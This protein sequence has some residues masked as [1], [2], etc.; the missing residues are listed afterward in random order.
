M[1]KIICIGDSL[2][3]GYGVDP[4]E[5]WVER[6]N[7][8]LNIQFINKGINGDT[9][10]GMLSRFHCDVVEEKPQ[11]VLI[12]GGVNDLI[13][14]SSTEM[15]GTNMMAMIHQA[16][17]YGIIPIAG[18]PIKADP[19]TFREDWKELT[20]VSRLNAEILEYRGILSKLCY[21]FHVD[22]IDFYSEFERKAGEPYSQCFLDGLHPTGKGHE[23]LADIA[24][25]KFG[26]IRF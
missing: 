18:A 4:G 25:E 23:I 2:T 12:L 22:Y 3:R 11:Y 26:G 17:H 9:T 10:G 24:A 1:K 14:G 8:R 16:Y 5:T 15:I 21:I 19:L 13:T 6:L 20:S 7:R